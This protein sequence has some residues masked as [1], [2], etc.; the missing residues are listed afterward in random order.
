CHENTNRET[1]EP[2][3][4]NPLGGK[5]RCRY[6]SPAG[7]VRLCDPRE[8]GVR[9][10]S[11]QRA[12]EGAAADQLARLGMLGEKLRQCG[13]DVL[14]DLARIVVSERGQDAH[15]GNEELVLVAAARAMIRNILQPAH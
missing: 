2:T 6:N 11:V 8:T 15:V 7:F 14:E 1:P 4:P 13:G 9:C 5:N 12:R 3:T 10:T